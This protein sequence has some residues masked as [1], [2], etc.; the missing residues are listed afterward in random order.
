MATETEKVEIK[1]TCCNCKR[2]FP[3]SPEF[4][5]DLVCQKCASG[6]PSTITKSIEDRVAKAQDLNR[7]LKR[8]IE[9]CRSQGKRTIPVN[10]GIF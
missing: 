7:I 4:C 3:Y 10:V 1:G 6:L 2:D 5:V 9:V 8:S